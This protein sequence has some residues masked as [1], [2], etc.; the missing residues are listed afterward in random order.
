MSANDTSQN[1][2]RSNQQASRRRKRAAT[3]RPERV[4]PDGVIPYVISG[5]FSG[6]CVSRLLL[7]R[8]IYV[9]YCLFFSSR[10]FSLLCACL[11]G[12]CLFP[13]SRLFSSLCL[14]SSPVLLSPPVSS[15]LFLS[16]WFPSSLL[17]SSCLFL[18]RLASPFFSQEYSFEDVKTSPVKFMQIS[19][20]S[21]CVC[22]CIHTL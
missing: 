2:A 9:L 14:I 20:L 12:S 3:S 1:A 11:I 13:W 8:F 21:V 15:N 16:H 4:W 6:K 10:L 22:S 17:G 19:H 5:N 18:P 7:M